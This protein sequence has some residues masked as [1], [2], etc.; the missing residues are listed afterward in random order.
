MSSQSNQ[1]V[2]FPPRTIRSY[3]ACP[4]NISNNFRTTTIEIAPP[5][6]KAT[7][8]P[9][10]DLYYVIIIN[11]VKKKKRKRKTVI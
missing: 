1:E 2:R 4:K 10:V 7:S 9:T 6:N 11:N 8:K 3:N 5:K